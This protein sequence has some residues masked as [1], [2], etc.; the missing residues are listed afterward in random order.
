MRNMKKELHQDVRPGTRKKK[1]EY[2]CYC[3]LRH[4]LHEGYTVK[5]DLTPDMVCREIDKGLEIIARSI[6]ELERKSQHAEAKVEK[7]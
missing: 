4:Q 6:V 2:C 5:N 1:I 3:T 7:S